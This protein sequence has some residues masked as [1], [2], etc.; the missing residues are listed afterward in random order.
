M[1]GQAAP[2]EAGGSAVGAPFPSSLRANVLLVLLVFTYIASFLDRQ[3]LSLMVGPI[4][5]SLKISDFQISLLQGFSFALFFCFAG[6]PLGW[7]ADRLRRGWIIAGGL[8]LW[9]IMTMACGFANGFLPLFVARVGVGVGEAALLPAGFSLLS[10]AFPP[11]RLVRAISIFSLGSLLG[12]GMAF[13]VGGTLIDYLSRTPHPLEFAGRQPW[14]LSFILVALPGLLLVPLLAFSH[15]PARRGLSSVTASNVAHT[16]AYIWGRRRDYAPFY[17]CATLLAVANYGGMAWFPTHMIRKFALSPMHAGM[18]LGALQLGGS[19]VGTMGGTL[20]T[21]HFLRRG[22]DDAH[23]RTV[24]LVSAVIAVAF[25][26]PLLSSVEG[27]LALWAVAVA[28]LAAY[29][30]SLASA[31]QVMTPNEMRATNSALV[32]LVQTLG[33]LG[34]GTALIGGLS[35][36]AFP[37]N[38]A[39]IGRSMALI[40]MT[41]AVASAGVAARG[42]PHFAQVMRPRS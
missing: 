3:I 22:R 29:Y 40:G 20:L 24:G 28:A 21:E 1:I 15:E 12:A 9:S 36:V 16:V 7:L 31:M 39:G 17:A 2:A 38:P 5:A 33:G 18:I 10:D 8:L 13:F 11:R 42:L 23:L 37:G 19:I 35:D 14:Q 34:L 30:G 41:A 32:L 27:A 6:V 25:A 4:R 26:A